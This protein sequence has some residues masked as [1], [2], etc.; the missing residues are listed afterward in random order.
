LATEFDSKP[1]TDEIRGSPGLA[2][3]R[4]WLDALTEDKPKQ[5][6]TDARARGEAIADLVRGLNGDPDLICGALLFPLVQAGTLD[7]AKI[8][9]RFGAAIATLV[10][11]LVALGRFHLPANWNPDSTLSR[12]QAESVRQMLLA[13]AS[14]VRLVLVRLAEQLDR[15]RRLKNGRDPERRAAAR[16]TQVVF[17][18]LANRLGIWQLK[19]ELEDLAFRFLEPATYKRIASALQQRRSDRERYILDVKHRLTAELA[20]Q[21]IKAEISG[22]PKHIYSIWRKMQRKQVGLDELF[23]IRAVRVLVESVADCYAA[24][25]LVHGLWHYIPGEFDDYIATPKENGYRSIHTAVIG[26]GGQP[27]EV[28][29]RSREMHEHAELGV[30][31]HWRYKEGGRGHRAF[32]EKINWLRQLLVPESHDDTAEDFIDRVRAEIFEDRVYV[33]SPRGDVV[34]LPQGATPLDFAYHVHTEVGHHCRGAKVN[35]RMVP[36][37]YVLNTGEQ[38]EII[39]A[40]NAHPSRDWLIP[41]RGYLASPRSRAKVRGWFR[42]EDQD[43]NRRQGRIMLDRELGKL[44]LKELKMPALLKS[45]RVG[46]LDELHLGLGSGEIS[47]AAVTQA[48][49]QQQPSTGNRSRQSSPRGQRSR[50]RG[51]NAVAVDGI[52]DLM[53]NFARCCRPVP[54]EPIAGYITKGR[55]VTIHR[56]QCRN[57]LRLRENQRERVLQVTWNEAGENAEHPVDIRIEAYDRQ[58]LTRDVTAVFADAKISIQEMKVATFPVHNTAQIDLRISV[59]GLEELSRILNRLSTLPNV[60]SAE[61]KD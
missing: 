46:N 47:L 25:G 50:A 26:P 61:R 33:I 20:R 2:D 3:V 39:T 6:V 40:K 44:G 31:A 11:G 1:N 51:R 21:G 10:D 4:D 27:L 13:I 23:D 37:T 8:Q 42:R 53:S 9:D 22:R 16:E 34:D 38:V 28:Q 54:P 58:G 18:P 56:K 48:V 12:D 30:A 36:L 32:D 35:G 55:G 15:M 52:G 19:W 14:D 7:A 5:P 41:Q 45:L 29:I 59:R 43:Q 24:L 49:A 57:L 60:I 17:A